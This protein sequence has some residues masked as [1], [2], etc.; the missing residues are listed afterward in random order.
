MFD[1]LVGLSFQEILSFCSLVS[2][3][4]WNLIGILGNL[5]VIGTGSEFEPAYGRLKALCSSKNVV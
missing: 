5:N 2:L 3:V 4:N 1:S